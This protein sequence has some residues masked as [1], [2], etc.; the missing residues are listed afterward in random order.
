MRDRQAKKYLITIKIRVYVCL[1]MDVFFCSLH[2]FYFD[3]Y[4]Y[5]IVRTRREKK[6]DFHGTSCLD[7]SVDIKY[8][9]EQYIHLQVFFR[10]CYYFPIYEPNSFIIYW[11]HLSFGLINIDVNINGFKL[12]KE[13]Y[14]PTKCP[15]RWLPDITPLIRM[16]VVISML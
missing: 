8:A 4:Y 9:Y 10:F 12:I 11:C 1:Q 6:N 13:C 3:Y 14:F 7:F 2:F 15:F 16:V 5:E